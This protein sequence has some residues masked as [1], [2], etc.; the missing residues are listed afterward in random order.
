MNSSVAIDVSASTVNGNVINGPN[1][2]IIADATGAVQVVNGGAVN[3]S[4]ENFGS[5][6]AIDTNATNPGVPPG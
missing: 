2:T 3:G 5:I 6:T 1:G 4:V